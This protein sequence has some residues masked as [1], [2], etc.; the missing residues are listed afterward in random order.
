MSKALRIET[1]LHR[2]RL[3]PRAVVAL[4]ARSG[5]C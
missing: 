1:G 3:D 4:A 5:G 2:R